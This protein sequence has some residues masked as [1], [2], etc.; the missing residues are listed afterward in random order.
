MNWNTENP[1]LNGTPIV[2]VGRIIYSDEFSTTSE[3]FA[4]AILWLKK[5][6]GFEGWCFYR[7][8]GHKSLARYTTDKIHIDFW[9]P[10]PI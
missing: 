8:G 6:S 9:M 10:Y 2:A 5:S 3:P 4:C 7:E 1:P